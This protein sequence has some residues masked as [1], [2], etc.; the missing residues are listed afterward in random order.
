M[1]QL[2]HEIKVLLNLKS[3][4]VHYIEVFVEAH[5]AMDSVLLCRV[6]LFG[7]EAAI[8]NGIVKY[9][10]ELKEG[11]YNVAEQKLIGQMEFRL[12]QKYIKAS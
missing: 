3:A 8:N 5:Y 10:A 1:I 6:E 9:E 11:F 4:E 2:E 7:S 12:V